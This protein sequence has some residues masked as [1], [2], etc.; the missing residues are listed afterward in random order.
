MAWLG[1]MEQGKMMDLR[2]GE[3]RD[4]LVRASK[5]LNWSTTE[6]EDKALVLLPVCPEMFVPSGD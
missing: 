3:K 2:L 5:D 1:R 6:N 4:L